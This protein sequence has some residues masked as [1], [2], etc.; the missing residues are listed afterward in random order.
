[1]HHYNP[2]RKFPCPFTSSL[3]SQHPLHWY[4]MI[5]CPI[6]PCSHLCSIRVHAFVPLLSTA[7][8]HHG[9]VALCHNQY[10]AIPYDFRPPLIM[11]IYILYHTQ[12]LLASCNAISI[13]GPWWRYVMMSPPCSR[14]VIISRTSWACINQD[15]VFVW[16][17]L[18]IEDIP[19]SCSCHAHQPPHS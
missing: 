9:D 17:T 10:A 19:A 3:C 15:F 14:H 12:C 6:W 11:V 18:M 16:C 1:M 4:S 2:L 7:S 8:T 5:W 13:F